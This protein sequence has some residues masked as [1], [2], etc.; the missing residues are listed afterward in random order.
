MFLLILVATSVS[1]ED[2]V[3][4]DVSIPTS[5]GTQPAS[6]VTMKSAK[7]EKV[8]AVGTAEKVATVKSVVASVAV[9][10]TAKRIVAKQAERN[11]LSK[12]KGIERIR[13]SS[14]VGSWK[15]KEGRRS[16]RDEAPGVSRAWTRSQARGLRRRSGRGTK[17]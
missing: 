12:V 8:T 3:Q 14:T 4:T 1:F 9:E 15:I 7:A 16:R 13:R 10:K 11:A 6:M 2:M 5:V 17:T